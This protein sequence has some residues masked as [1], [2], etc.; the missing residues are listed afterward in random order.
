MRAEIDMRTFARG[1][2][3][4][5]IYPAGATIFC[6]GDLGRTM[7][8]VQSGLIEMMIGDTVVDTCGPNEAIG[9]MSVIDGA[10][11][12]DSPREGGLRSF[13]DRRTAIPI[14]GG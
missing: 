8:I 1:A 14:H 9:F 7:F 13:G 11:H 4:T 10:Q 12:H 5:L 3:T 2:C 6:Q